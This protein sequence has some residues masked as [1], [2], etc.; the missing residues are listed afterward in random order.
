M[1]DLPT[2]PAA[3]PRRRPR[4]AA[5]SRVRLSGTDRIVVILM[6]ADPDARGRGPGVAAG[7]RLGGAVVH[8]L[9]R[10]RRPGSPSSGSGTENYNN[11]FTNYP[12]FWPGAAAQPDLAGCS[13]SCVPTPFGMLPRRAAR[14]GAARH[15]LLPDR[16]LPAGGAVAGADRLHLAAHLLPRPGPAQRRARAPR[17]TG[18]ATPDVQPLGG[19]GGRRLAARRL[20]HAA[21]PGR[22]EGGRP[23]AARGR[24]RGRR[25][26]GAR[27]SSGSSSR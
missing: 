14:P 1:T 19:A 25:Q 21:V 20:H 22:A 10:H 24:R 2:V 4:A 18:T 15:P 9:E 11:V 5:G 3:P 27:P 12:P 26:R 16:A 6:V 8:Q 17:S 13:C 23:L 7:D